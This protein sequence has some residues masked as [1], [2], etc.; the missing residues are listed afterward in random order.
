MIIEVFYPEL[1]P[2]PGASSLRGEIFLKTIISKK[3]NIDLINI[4]STNKENVFDNPKIR[5]FFFKIICT[6]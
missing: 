6:K 4:Y 1:P 5:H 2:N 3:K